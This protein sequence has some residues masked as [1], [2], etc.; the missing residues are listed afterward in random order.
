MKFKIIYLKKRPNLVLSI[1]PTLTLLLFSCQKQY[2][3]TSSSSTNY[4]IYCGSCHLPPDPKNIPKEIWE[5]GVLPEMAARMGYR[6]NGFDPYSYKSSEEIAYIEQSRVYPDHPTIDSV[7]WW[8][9]HDYIISLA[10]NSIPIEKTRK[11]RNKKLTQ[12]S[13]SKVDPPE[14]TAPILTCMQYDTVRNVFTIG[15]ATGNLYQWPSSNKNMEL[16]KRNSAMTAYQQKHDDLYITEVGILNPSE[17]PRG[18]IT[19][20]SRSS[21]DTIAIELHRPVFTEICD[22]NKDGIDELLICEFGHLTGQLSL[23]EQKK[24]SYHRKSLYGF[25]GATKVEIADMDGDGKKDIVTLFAQGNEGIFI[26]YQKESLE[27]VNQQIIQ[28]PPEFGA[29]WFELIDY[30]KD[31]DLDIILTNGDN[32]DYSIFYK[33]Y[34]GIRLFLNDG[35]N[36]FKEE[37]FYPIYGASRVLADDYD[38]DGD[39][40]FAVT[41]L[42]NDTQ[43][44]PAEGFIYLENLT[45]DKFDF[46]PYTIEGDFTNGWLT[47]AKGDYDNDGDIDIMVGSFEVKGLRKTSFFKSSHANLTKILLLENGKKRKT[48]AQVLIDR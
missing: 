2:R 3:N 35:T 15:D 32:A 34:H 18:L 27:F 1:L 8:S 40:D 29:S 28:L 48:V 46:Q 12:F 37:W 19:K 41:A 23:L 11:A 33:P 17:V 42:F 5:K 39:I 30:D 14:L 16:E 10:P 25:P 31:G 4:N 36:S 9:L 6:Y 47:M 38:L 13:V 44:A 20:I 21:V 43:N 24:G 22:L 7:T 26:F 45:S